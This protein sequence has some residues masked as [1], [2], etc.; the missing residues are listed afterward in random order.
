M[1]S[2]L[3]ASLVLLALCAVSVRAASESAALDALMHYESGADAT[4]LRHYEQLV[5]QSV[6]DA[7]LRKS[8][9]A[10]LVRVLAGDSTFEA[11]RF[12]CLNL[13]VIGTEASVPALAAW[14]KPDETV[15]IACAALAQNPSPKATAELRKALGST[16]GRAQAQVAHALGVRQDTKAVAQLSQLASGSDLDAAEAAI[17]ALG[18]IGTPAAIK[19]IDQ[20]RE[21][22]WGFDEQAREEALNAGMNALRAKAEGDTNRAEETAGKAVARISSL[23]GGLVP[24]TPHADAI[25]AASLQIA[26]ELVRRGSRSKAAKIYEE[27]VG[28][29]QPAGSTGAMNIAPPLYVR[30]AGLH[31]LLR[32]DQ[33]TSRQWIFKILRSR[34]AALK[35]V[36]IAAIVEIR[37]ADASK[38]F[39]AELPKLEPHEQVLLIEALAQRSDAAART[40]IQGQLGATEKSV[41]LAAIQAVGQDGDAATVPVLA[42]VLLDAKDAD[43]LKAVELALASLPAKADVDQALGAQLRNRMA[44]PKAPI[45]AAMVHR[46]SP[47]S[48]PLFLAETASSDPAMVRLAFQGLSRTAA[49][50][51]LPAVLKAL[52]SLQTEA[53][54][55]DAQAAVGQLL[56]RVGTPAGNATAVRDALKAAPGAA[57][58]RAYLPLLAMCP[59]AEGLAVV[60]A[61]AGSSDTATRDIGLRTLADWPEAS[62][63]DPLFAVY[64]KATAETERVLALRGLARLLGE[65]NAKPDAQLIAR[66]RALLAGAKSDSDRKL[67]LGP[68]ASCAHPDALKLA[69]EQLAQPGVRAE[70]AQAVKSIAEAIK[71]QHPQEAAAALKALQ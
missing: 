58:S 16:K 38:A 42:R 29:V 61:T 59:E 12:A 7:A 25:A 1:K 35:P 60:V 20:L 18:K 57:G 37:D 39:A 62:A 56:R 8:V 64:E 30:R 51:D 50:G 41:R 65:E 63:W 21:G 40:A 71:P 2:H 19:V 69:V 68:L 53:A 66:Y 27:L 44:G 26:D 10:D 45:L 6:N 47:A 36:A 54:L 70:A 14:L 34:E 9:E 67:V 49:A 46:A 4:P 52:G 13:A 5:A 11:K 55:D 22:A 32:L 31:G 33:K 23:M 3:L 48:V 17:I 28:W 24:K 43:E 15:G